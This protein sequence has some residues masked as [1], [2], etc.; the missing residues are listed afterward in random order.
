MIEADPIVSASTAVRRQADFYRCE[1][2][3][4]VAAALA[5][6]AIT[7]MPALGAYG[8]TT[9]PDDLSSHGYH[10]GLTARSPM[11]G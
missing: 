3:P 9:I 1:D 10:E 4:D 5:L 11:A 6:R 2:D 7:V 8:G